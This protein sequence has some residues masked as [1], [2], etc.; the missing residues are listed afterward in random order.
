MSKVRRIIG[1]DPGKQTGLAV[2]TV[3]PSDTV[4][5]ALLGYHKIEVEVAIS[6]GMADFPDVFE[7]LLTTILKLNDDVPV[8]IALERF[9]VTR[10]TVATQ[11]TQSLEIIGA[12]HAIRKLFAAGIPITMQAPSEAKPMFPGSRLKELTNVKG[13]DDHTRDALRHAFTL[14]VKKIQAGYL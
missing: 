4:T 1:I 11:E 7:G 10:M 5:H 3:S 12:V 2:V 6:E 9:I 8:E 13:M 14:A